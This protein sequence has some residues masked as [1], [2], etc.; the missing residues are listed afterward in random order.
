MYGNVCE[1]EQKNSAREF[2][3]AVYIEGFDTRGFFTNS[4]FLGNTAKFGGAVAVRNQALAIF[5]DTTFESKTVNSDTGFECTG[6]I[7]A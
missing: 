4:T 1:R 7:E 6:R 3:G 2:G 5:E